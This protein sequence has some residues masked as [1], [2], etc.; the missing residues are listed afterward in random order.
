MK[1]TINRYLE[2]YKKFN[3]KE[4][5]ILI[6]IILIALS[7]FIFRDFGVL[8]VVSDERSYSMVSRLIE[9]SKS[10]LPNYLYLKI[11]STTN[12]CGDSFYSCAKIIN[13]VFYILG[14]YF[15]YKISKFSAV[16]KW[17]IIIFAILLLLPIN[18][19][20]SYFMPESMYFSCFW[21]LIYYLVII[22]SSN[23]EN[24]KSYLIL[25]A[26]TAI[27]SL[28]KPHGVFII[29]AIIIYLAYINN[30]KNDKILTIKRILFYILS[31][32][33][34]RFALGYFLAGDNGINLFGEAYNSL[35][36][37]I[38][39]NRGDI[40]NSIFEQ[41]KNICGHIFPMIF[42]YFLPLIYI[43]N[44]LIKL[45]ILQKNNKI[46]PMALLFL[47]IYFIM[48]FIASYFTI[49]VSGYSSYEVI[50]RIH[51]RYYNFILPSILILL[52][53]FLNENYYS[54]ISN[55][56]KVFLFLIFIL[57]FVFIINYKLWFN[58][59]LVDSPEI[60]SL[61]FRPEQI[62]ILASLLFI[63]LL[64]FFYNQRKGL[65]FYILIF[66]PTYIA[67]SIY[68]THTEFKQRSN[69]DIY[70]SAGFFAKA[71]L[72]KS[73]IS[74]L[75]I[76]SP[77]TTGS[78]RTMFILN[79]AE[80]S[81]IELPLNSSVEE[82]IKSMPSKE[83]VLTI[84]RYPEPNNITFG[85]PSNGSSLY[86]I[87]KEIVL[88]FTRSSWPGIVESLSG[89]YPSESWGAW[90]EGKEVSIKFSSFLPSNFNLKLNIKSFGDNDSII[91]KIGTSQYKIKINSEFNY[92]NIPVRDLPGK[93]NIISFYI[94]NPISPK[95][96]KI[97]PDERLIGLGFKSLEIIPISNGY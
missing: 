23:I 74:K 42:I 58:P 1:N 12:M 28:I 89:I 44:Q 54:T 6:L 8:N 95:A 94:K 51:S 55:K 92:Y 91:L 31:F 69:P 84:G 37:K 59:N 32:I 96:L 88:P 30:T 33:F 93:N 77:E 19:Y 82:T 34:I 46:L 21:L 76:I 65:L 71:L 17:S 53:Y 81:C 7:F 90:S 64:L 10:P 48:V 70:D 67:G 41:I 49:S 72:P 29:P 50:N 13:E 20:T 87:A 43:F 36:S 5:S 9:L 63:S 62:Y 11:Y 80:I 86:H 56:I 4:D 39:Y 57:L 75:L 18:S 14:C 40:L 26:M 2:F 15:I 38:S 79:N 68:F 45:N 78:F 16:N 60:A 83:W 22:V 3:L 61:V 24:I 47:A 25:G 35:N 27:L 97:N 73:E 66:F 85:M 52:S